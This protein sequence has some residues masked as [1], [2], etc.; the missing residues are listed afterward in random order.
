MKTI[1]D[2]NIHGRISTTWMKKVFQPGGGRDG[3]KYFISR[4]ER[5]CYVLQSADIEL[6]TVIEC[7][8]ADGTVLMPGFVFI[9]EH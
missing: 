6:V 7:C 5:G 4:E 3:Q 9:S 2:N 1:R 8:S